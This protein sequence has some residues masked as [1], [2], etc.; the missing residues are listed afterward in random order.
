VLVLK[1]GRI[2]LDLP[3]EA[4]RPRQ[5]DDR[6]LLALERQVLAAV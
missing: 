4:D 5:P 1:H 6:R 3:V 2:D